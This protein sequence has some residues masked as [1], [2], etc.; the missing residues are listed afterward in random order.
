MRIARLA[1][2]EVDQRARDCL[3]RLDRDTPIDYRELAV[4][5]ACEWGRNPPVRVGLSGGQGAG[6]STLGTL[7][8]SASTELGL[9]ACVLSL[10]DFYLPKAERRALAERVHPLFETRGPPG[11]HDTSLCAACL[12]ALEEAQEVRLPV[13]DKG[14]DDRLSERVVEGPFD[15]VILEGWCVGARA[16]AE[17][18]LVGPLNSLEA[19]CDA[20]GIWRRT[21]NRILRED[22]EPL[23][24][25]LDALVFLGVP[26]IDAVRRW[27]S[28]QEQARPANQRM[29]AGE[30]D[31]FVQHYERITQ[32]MLEDASK[33]VDWS[34]RLD[35]D[36][37]IAAVAVRDQ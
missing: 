11:T 25:S 15:L 24:G 33:N 10:D 16:V 28:Q 31:R 26:N 18:E 37:R 2:I 29:N 8:E 35:E 6:K 36:H 4:L 5:L 13:F 20:D 30:V 19:E 7:I 34:I 32:R 14:V 3:A 21:V 1:G 12:D 22:Y 9:R 23:W 27:R 17:S